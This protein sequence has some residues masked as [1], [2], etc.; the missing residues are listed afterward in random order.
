MQQHT[1][2]SRPVWGSSGG[3]EGLR[4]LSIPF[5]Q[6]TVVDAASMEWDW[7][8]AYLGQN[9][10]VLVYPKISLFSDQNGQP[11]ALSPSLAQF[12][13]TSLSI[14]NS[15]LLAP[16]VIV[17][18]NKPY[19]YRMK[20][21]VECSSVKLQELEGKGSIVSR[22]QKTWVQMPPLILIICVAVDESL[23]FDEPQ[24]YL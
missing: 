14:L 1:Q 10:L 21:L 23:H 6:A 7:E 9:L 3:Q 17:W 15:L 16:E 2:H 18:E 8:F 12:L 22:I 11:Q 4:F 24:L 20:N 13:Q 19:C 5:I